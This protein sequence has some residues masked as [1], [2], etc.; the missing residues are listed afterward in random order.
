[1]TDHDK[2]FVKV[3]IETRN[4]PDASI[5]VQEFGVEH[6]WPLPEALA[7]LV[8]TCAKGVVVGKDPGA[9]DDFYKASQAILDRV[10]LLKEKK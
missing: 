4:W 7:S 10:E 3:S 9:M 1:M 6:D 5:H 2:T 8:H